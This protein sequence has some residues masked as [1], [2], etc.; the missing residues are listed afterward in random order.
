MRK[1]GYQAKLEAKPLIELLS[2]RIDRKFRAQGREYT[3]DFVD[4][5]PNIISRTQNQLLAIIK[6]V[7]FH[8]CTFYEDI[9]LKI[10]EGIAQRVFL[11][12]F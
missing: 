8:R 10:L 1:C 5:F 9:N 4:T 6:V 7:K 11:T 3:A 2:S 12:K